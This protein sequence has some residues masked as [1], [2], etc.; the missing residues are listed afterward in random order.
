MAGEQESR[1]ELLGHK[2]LAEVREVMAEHERWVSARVEEWHRQQEITNQMHQRCIEESLS[3]LQ[4]MLQNGVAAPKRVLETAT[5]THVVRSRDVQEPSLKTMTPRSLMDGISPYAPSPSGL[6]NENISDIDVVTKTIDT[7]GSWS[8]DLTNVYHE[9]D[10][11]VNEEDRGVVSNS[12]VQYFH[13]Q[14]SFRTSLSEPLI[15]QGMKRRSRG[16][17]E[18]EPS[19]LKNVVTHPLFDGILGVAILGNSVFIGYSSDYAV[20][21]PENPTN[22]LIDRTEWFFT[23]LFTIE[24]TFRLI[25]WKPRVFFW[26]EDCWWNL[27]DFTLVTTSLWSQLKTVDEGIGEGN[28]PNTMGLRVL[29]LLRLLKM[30]RVV[31]IARFMRELRTIVSSI[32]GSVRTLFWSMVMLAIILY[33]FGLVFL[34]AATSVLPDK[35]LD[36]STREQLLDYFGSVYKS[37]LTLYMATT[38]GAD[39]GPMASPLAAAGV[40]YYYLFLFYISLLSMAIL[41]VVM[42]LFVDA[43]MKAAEIDRIEMIKEAAEDHAGFQESIVELFK[44]YDTN[45]DGM[46][47][48]PELVDS[49][50]HPKMQAF[51]QHLD[52]DPTEVTTVFEILD[53]GASGDVP[54]E[55]LVQG[56]FKVS[57]G[58]KS[59]DIM[60]L[61][62][63]QNEIKHKLD[64]LSVTMR[65]VV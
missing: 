18:E 17:V 62:E 63:S 52:V 51:M 7:A 25:V 12:M 19:L 10:V 48:K 53:R 54:L 36:N 15:N 20:Q 58:A 11:A 8:A 38:G 57:R 29:R 23:I 13:E 26:G 14:R 16:D 42:G 59:I 39:W 9:E 60:Q 35:A 22:A 49:Y 28:V 41:N 65:H 4:D 37:M 55:S 27:F 34:Q 31:R 24:V 5:S 6:P 3:K 21:H 44:E 33:I 1:F 45:H 30:F 32:V 2:L 43:A 40:G 61:L 47:D 50:K 64:K 46:I 56:C